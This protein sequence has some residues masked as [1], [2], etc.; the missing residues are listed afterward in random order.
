M[1]GHGVSHAVV[2]PDHLLVLG[3]TGGALFGL[4]FLVQRQRSRKW[5]QFTGAL[6]AFGSLA[7]WR[8]AA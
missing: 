1:F 5:M 3:L 8:F 7:A 4:G 6:L 2:S